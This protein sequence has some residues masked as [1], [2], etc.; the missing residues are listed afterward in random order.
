MNVK[1]RETLE[2]T[3]KK[4]KVLVLDTYRNFIREE[5]VDHPVGK[6]LTINSRVPPT[7]N[8]NHAHGKFEYDI[9]PVY[10][11]CKFADD[12]CLYY[13]IQPEVDNE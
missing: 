4:D 1:R 10:L 11:I 5:L 2:L 7:T 6:T 13:V 12:S 9:V 8:W 3:T